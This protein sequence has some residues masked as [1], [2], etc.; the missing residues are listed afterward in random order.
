MADLADAQVSDSIEPCPGC[1][2]KK[3]GLIFR[4]GSD[5]PERQANE[6]CDD[7]GD[8]RPR[9]GAGKV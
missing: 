4:D 7:C 5:L 3:F 8:E 2:G 1:G 6:R 9:E